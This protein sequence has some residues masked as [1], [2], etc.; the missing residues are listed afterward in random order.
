MTNDREKRR[1]IKLLVIFSV[2]I[3]LGMIAWGYFES[4][5]IAPYEVARRDTVYI[6]SAE[7]LGTLTEAIFN[8]NCYLTSDIRITD[9]STTIGTEEYPFSGIF[10]GNGHTIYLSYETVDK[11]ISL[12]GKIAEGAVIKNVNFVIE[13][14]VV[15]ENIGLIARL[16]E[17]T[18]SNCTITFSDL[19]INAPNT[20]SPLVS[21]NKGVISNIYA[22][23]KFVNNGISREDER[24]MAVAALCIYNWGAIKNSIVEVEYNGF[25]S[26]DKQAVFDGIYSNDSM[27]AIV[28][29]NAGDGITENNRAIVSDSTY[30]VDNSIEFVSNQNRKSIFDEIM[31]FKTLDFDNRYW[32]L[33]N[34][35]LTLILAEG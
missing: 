33:T 28:Y 27:A 31:V 1:Y 20:I 15:S 6:S 7:Q 2:I 11:N 19:Q 4:G 21:A 3:S 23:G 8:D 25:L 5:E 10:D 16:N 18:I 9:P 24:K 34:E 26:T 17:G 12:F 35:K 30:L 32:T 14:M 13:P 22:S 29:S